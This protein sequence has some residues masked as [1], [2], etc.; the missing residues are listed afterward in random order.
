MRSP[1]HARSPVI[2]VPASMSHQ[3]SGRPA[4]TRSPPIRS[5]WLRNF[6]PAVSHF[7]LPPRRL[8]HL[9]VPRRTGT[10]GSAR[11]V[12]GRRRHRVGGGVRALA[13]SFCVAD[14]SQFAA[15]CDPKC[16]V[17]RRHD[18]PARSG[19]GIARG[20]LVVDGHR[21]PGLTSRPAIATCRFGSSSPGR[22]SRWWPACTRV[23][24][25]WW[26]LV[27]IAACWV[28]LRPPLRRDRR[29]WLALAIV[30]VAIVSR[31][32]VFLLR[33]LSFGVSE[34]LGTP[35]DI[36]VVQIAVSSVW[37]ALD[38]PADTVGGPAGERRS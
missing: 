20:C 10:P 15:G 38:D 29:A 25:W 5:R 12:R 13:R 8:A 32:V 35:S 23:L 33:S 17:L 7:V 1:F 28:A 37:R 19:A 30:G 6:C 24:S 3:R 26:V 21:L 14:A 34:S 4:P 16:V 9:P 22:R 18:Q 11:R 36:S 2:P 27:A 31:A